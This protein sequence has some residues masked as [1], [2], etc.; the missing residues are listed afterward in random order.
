MNVL[1]SIME[2]RIFIKRQS[3]QSFTLPLRASMGLFSCMDKQGLEKLILCWEIIRKR[4][5]NLQRLKT[6]FQWQIEQD[7][8][9][10]LQL[11]EK[12]QMDH[13]LQHI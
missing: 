3:N 7:L 5:E 4:F 13:I 11:K 1:M 12:V 10:E 9:A 8:A 6:V 2:M